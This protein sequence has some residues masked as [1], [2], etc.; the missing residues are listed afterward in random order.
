M[1]WCLIWNV[2]CALCLLVLAEP[3]SKTMAQESSSSSQFEQSSVV[4][5][6]IATVEGRESSLS[7]SEAQKFWMRLGPEIEL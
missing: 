6:R 3:F 1:D 2:F 5:S 7:D 4:A